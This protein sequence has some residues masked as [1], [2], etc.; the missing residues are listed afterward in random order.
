MNKNKE[1]SL[2]FSISTDLSLEDLRNNELF[3]NFISS[4]GGEYNIEKVVFGPGNFSISIDLGEP[5]PKKKEFILG[6][7]DL[8]K[9]L[10]GDIFKFTKVFSLGGEAY[11]INTLAPKVISEENS[12]RRKVA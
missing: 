1:N 10:L 8:G 7:M 4:F 11:E 3:E 9:K 6:H 12:W 2:N 5:A